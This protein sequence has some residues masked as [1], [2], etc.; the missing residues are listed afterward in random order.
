M[1]WGGGMVSFTSDA[2]ASDLSTR[3]CDI[4]KVLKKDRHRQTNAE[5]HRDAGPGWSG[6]SCT[7]LY[8]PRRVRSLG[9]GSPRPAELSN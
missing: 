3:L 7:S 8:L 5:V 9:W 4:G 1:R 2:V 6:G